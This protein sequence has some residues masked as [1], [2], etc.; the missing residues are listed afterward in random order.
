MLDVVRPST[1][2]QRRV[3]EYALSEHSDGCDSLSLS[4]SSRISPS[5]SMSSSSLSTANSSR[6]SSSLSSYRGISTRSSTSCSDIDSRQVLTP[7]R[8]YINVYEI[9]KVRSHLREVMRQ[10]KELLLDDVEY[11]QERIEA[12]NLAGEEEED[13]MMSGD[14]SPTLEELREV[15]NHLKYTILEERNKGTLNKLLSPLSSSPSL[16]LSPGM[17]RS[18]LEM[19]PPSPSLSAR[20]VGAPPLSPLNPKS[21][22]QQKRAGSAS[23]SRSSPSRTL[24]SRESNGS[25][26]TSRM[27]PRPPSSRPGNAASP[28]LRRP[29]LRP[30]SSSS[31]SSP[32]SSLPPSSLPPISGGSSLARKL[33]STIASAQHEEDELEFFT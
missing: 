11:L 9:E 6:P 24:L 31:P 23:K 28:R 16:S 17:R 4:S 19:D 25:G 5:G 18:Q 13:G 21:L 12:V 32:S 2:R 30:S 15:G 26:S 1:A 33:R 3:V 20:G 27:V 10:E 7:I 22:P 14:E 8:E 29:T